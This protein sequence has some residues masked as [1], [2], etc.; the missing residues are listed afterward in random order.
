VKARVDTRRACIGA[1]P[2]E[3]VNFLFSS[4]VQKFA[5]HVMTYVAIDPSAPGV[6]AEMVEALRGRVLFADAKGLRVWN[7]LASKGNVTRTRWRATRDHEGEGGSLDDAPAAALLPLAAARDGIIRP[8]SRTYRA[9]EGD[10][11]ELAIARGAEEEA[12]RWL[13]EHGWETVR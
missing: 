7:A 5:R 12:E 2:N 4:R 11:V 3:S 10:V 6:S 1:T 9:K 8:M 13:L